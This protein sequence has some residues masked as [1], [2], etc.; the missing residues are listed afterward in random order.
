MNEWYFNKLEQVH[1]GHK[2]AT[3]RELDSGIGKGKVGKI[4][5]TPQRKTIMKKLRSTTVLF[6]ATVRFVFPQM[7]YDVHSVQSKAPHPV[8]VKLAVC[9]IIHQLLL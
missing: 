6:C 4:W 1:V 3:K 8:L 7:L 2:D 9:I 5:N